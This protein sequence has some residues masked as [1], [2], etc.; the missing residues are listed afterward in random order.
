MKLF[1]TEKTV[2]KYIKEIMENPPGLG[3]QMT[4]DLSTSPVSVSSVVDSSAALTD[5]G[6]PKFVPTNRVEL[7]TVLSS[8]VNDVP[9]DEISG[10]YST[11][12]DTI[13]DI[14]KDEDEMSKEDK[15]VEETIRASIRNMIK[16]SKK[17]AIPHLTLKE[18]WQHSINEA[19]LTSGFL[20]SADKEEM[21]A[22]V[23]ALPPA[24]NPNAIKPTRYP[25]GVSGRPGAQEKEPTKPSDE[26][27]KRLRDL[28]NSMELSSEDMQLIDSIKSEEETNKAI[29]AALD[30]VPDADANAF[31][32][33]FNETKETFR[34]AG[35]LSDADAEIL[36]RDSS[37]TQT[38]TFKDLF[39]KNLED[40]ALK[41]GIKVRQIFA[42]AGQKKGER[43]YLSKSGSE[44]LAGTAAALGPDQSTGKN[45]SVSQVNKISQRAL[46]KYI[47]ALK[48]VKLGITLDLNDYND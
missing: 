13:E 22:R 17:A 10:F 20:S 9:D 21:S 30:Q 43:G 6:N 29:A 39:G 28:L 41:L 42:G 27:L 24:L 15:K 16:E 2:R 38:K 1:V 48:C 35:E 5:P 37:I 4:G 23:A 8:L 34:D 14:N 11:I 46:G 18:F 32:N 40:Y 25:T 12:K 44:T 19:G 33:A 45:W 3:W 7:Q 47:L 26:E 36:T 31:C